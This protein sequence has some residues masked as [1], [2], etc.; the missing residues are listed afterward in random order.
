MQLVWDSPDDFDLS[1]EEPD[2]TLVDF[3]NT[4]STYGKLNG[5]NNKGFCDSGLR[6]G[7]ENILYFP[8]RDIPFGTYR[9]KVTHSNKCGARPTRWT[10][11]IMKNGIV[12][13][14]RTARSDKGRNE[15]VLNTIFKFP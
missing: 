1:V 12:V 10:L 4:R 6:V 13:K 9:V 7:K 8:N 14:R 2:G 11:S 15:Q 3:R 5:D